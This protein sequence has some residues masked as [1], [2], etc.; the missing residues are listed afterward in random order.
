MVPTV[1]GNWY[2]H[3]YPPVYYWFQG[4]FVGHDL[5]NA[6]LLMRLANILL[7]VGLT[8]IIC[9]LLPTGLRR[10][11]IGGALITAV[12]LSTFL[13]ASVNPSGWAILS[14][15]TLLV[16]LLGALTATDRRRRIALGGLAAF[17]L[18][19]GAGARADSA[20]YAIAAITVA[21]ILTVRPRPAARGLRMLIYPLILGTAAFIA[22]LAA[23]QSS[24]ALDYRR[25]GNPLTFAKLVDSTF[26]APALW[27]GGFGVRGLGWLDVPLPSVVW[28]GSWSVFAAVLFVAV[29]GVGP[30]S[31]ISLGLVILAVLAVPTYIL[32][33]WGGVGVQPR[34]VLPMLVMLAVLA[35]VRMDGMAFRLT[36]GQRWI[37]VTLL[38]IAN[39][40]A[41][42]ANIKRYTV[43]V[44]GTSWNLDRRIE[45]WWSIPASPMTV[46]FV[47]SLGFGLAAALLTREL[48]VA[49]P[50]SGQA[51]DPVSAAGD[52]T[53]TAPPSGDRGQGLMRPP[54]ERSAYSPSCR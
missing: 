39:A 44:D 49:A 7:F 27:P 29:T 18:L 2:S 31:R 33:R 23:G 15:L 36:S 22:F 54:R 12:P 10:S 4:F 16:S 26:G 40:V 17:S 6:V 53:S 3:G 34:Y 35:M 24:A 14:A 37:V 9:L 46:W 8:T 38:T 42:L 47:G 25:P 28:I 13:V 50:A 30:R 51:A 1:R 52:D 32:F 5:G 45:W 48:T 11:L 43:G 19:L 21:V 41:L 20:A